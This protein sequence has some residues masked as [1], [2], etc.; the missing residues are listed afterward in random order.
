[1]RKRGF[2]LMEL[3]VYMFLFVLAGMALY[4]LY[5]LGTKFSQSTLSSYL[6]SGD[7]ETAIRWLRRDIQET[8]LVSMR[9]YPG[10]DGPTEKPG[11][12]FLSAR[13]T[14]NEDP[15]NLNVSKYGTSL[16]TKYVFYSLVPSTDRIGDLV[17]WEKALDKVDKDFIPHPV[18]LATTPSS[19]LSSKLRMVRLKQVLLP[20]VKVD[21]LAGQPGYQADEFGGFKVQ[22]IRRKGGE[23]GAEELTSVNPGDNPKAPKP[24][25]NTSLISVELK[26]L[27]NDKSKPS[28]YDINF[29]VHPRY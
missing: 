13:N 27:S 7:T 8:A 28:F 17:R 24:E 4:Q 29:R 21:G 12:S 6:V 25:D 18:D 26:I 22:Y 16:W 9:T 2:T 10:Q 20:N 15:D 1:M 23:A 5:T 14:T 11:C 19:G 3:T